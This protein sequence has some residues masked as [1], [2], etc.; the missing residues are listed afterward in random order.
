MIGRKEE[1]MSKLQIIID[2]VAAAIGAALGFL[3]GEVNGLFWALIAFMALDYIT[4][5]IVAVINKRLSSEVGFKGLAK[6]FLIL[7]F[8][9][10][11]H[12]ADTYILGGTP[13]AMSAV[14]LFY[15][16]NEGISIIENAAA[17]GLPVPEKL[18]DIMEQIKTKS[19]SEEK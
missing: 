7:V 1:K 9:A 14:M 17:L 6:K 4:G 15:I 8:V 3:F 11:G 2:S 18:K 12:I 10:I 16:A 13:A 5:V 19:E